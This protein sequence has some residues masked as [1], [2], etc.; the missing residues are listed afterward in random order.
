KG[1]GKWGPPGDMSAGPVETRNQP[2]LHRVAADTEYNRCA[3]RRRF[4]GHDGGLAAARDDDG[5]LLLDELRCQLRQ[6]IVLSVCPAVF[7]LDVLPIH[8]TGAPET[9]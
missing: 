9:L 1:G 3:A 6:A 2:E 5:N 8:V 4:C 7:D